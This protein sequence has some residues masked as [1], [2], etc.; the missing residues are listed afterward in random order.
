ML[1][2]RILTQSTVTLTYRDDCKEKQIY[3][4]DHE[5]SAPLVLWDAVFW[6][7]WFQKGKKQTNS[8]LFRCTIPCHLLC[9]ECETGAIHSPLVFVLTV[10]RPVWYGV[11]DN[12]EGVNQTSLLSLVTDCVYCDKIT[13]GITLQWFSW[14]NCSLLKLP[15]LLLDNGIICSAMFSLVLFFLRL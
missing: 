4:P 13:A 9:I 10:L 3:W 11:P 7:V 15:L 1:Y 2:L 8:A 6:V 5:I 14:Q 12:K